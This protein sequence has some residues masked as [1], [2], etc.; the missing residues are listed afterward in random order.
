MFRFKNP[1][2]KFRN[3]LKFKFA[4]RKRRYESRKHEDHRREIEMLIVMRDQGLMRK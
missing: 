1:I 2:G 3:P 4:R